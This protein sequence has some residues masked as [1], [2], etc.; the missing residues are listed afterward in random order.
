MIVILLVRRAF[1]NVS[2]KVPRFDHSEFKD[3]PN[4]SNLEGS[5]RVLHRGELLLPEARS[6][7]RQEMFLFHH[8]QKEW[9]LANLLSFLSGL[10]IMRECV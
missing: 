1:A 9:I 7:K 8:L 3:V 6:Q 10:Q 5:L 4:F 2:Q